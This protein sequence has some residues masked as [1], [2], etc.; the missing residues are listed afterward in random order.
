MPDH[1][2]NIIIETFTV[3]ADGTGLIESFIFTYIH[4]ESPIEI[5]RLP[6]HPNIGAEAKD[7]KAKPQ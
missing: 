2:N 4:D 7:W 1:P 3:F 6:R 5:G